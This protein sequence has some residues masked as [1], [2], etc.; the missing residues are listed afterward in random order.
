MASH[1][2]TKYFNRP[3]VLTGSSADES[4]NEIST[5]ACPSVEP[6]RDASEVSRSEPQGVSRF[7][8]VLPVGF[9]PRLGVPV[10]IQP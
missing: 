4:G 10:E 9:F 5:I 1:W 8:T 2:F 6:L 7:P 3:A